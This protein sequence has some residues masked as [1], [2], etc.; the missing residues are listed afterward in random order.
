MNLVSVT[1]RLVFFL[2]W[3]KAALEFDMSNTDE[4]S[5]MSQIDAMQK[6]F[7]S[8]QR[9]ESLLKL[10]TLR[11][12]SSQA[13][14]HQHDTNGWFF[15]LHVAQ[16][17]AS[18]L[19][20]LNTS[21]SSGSE[22]PHT[23]AEALTIVLEN[24]PPLSEIPPHAVRQV[25]KGVMHAMSLLRYAQF[26]QE[27]GRFW[28]VSNGVPDLHNDANVSYWIQKDVAALKSTNFSNGGWSTNA[29]QTSV[30]GAD[31]HVG[32]CHLFRIDAAAIDGPLELNRVLGWFI[33]HSMPVVVS[34]LTDEWRAHSNWAR[35]NLLQAHGEQ[36]LQLG[37]NHQGVATANI[38]VG[39]NNDG[40][41]TTLGD[42]IKQIMPSYEAPMEGRKGKKGKKGKKGRKGKKGKRTW[43]SIP[44]YL[45]NSKISKG[46]ASQWG[47]DFDNPAC[48]KAAGLASGTPFV[49]TPEVITCAC[50]RCYQHS[51]TSTRMIT[52]EHFPLS[53]FLPTRV[54]LDCTD[55]FPIPF[56]PLSRTHLLSAKLWPAPPIFIVGPPLSGAE[57]HMHTAAWN[58]M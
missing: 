23:A 42:Y 54:A 8:E 34:G 30:G 57:L 46:L 45:F 20:E 9:W 19:L 15:A 26:V 56:S 25:Q 51:T 2:S 13:M 37:N 32:R 31:L 39:Q 35:E 14:L 5:V 50:M 29:I 3:S 36:P 1:V 55:C 43:G 4:Q 49:E 28:N 40:G 53:H 33:Q 17:Y 41:S 52:Q 44:P 47:A 48:F 12:K 18:V 6:R 58:G 21:T 22:L 27:R 10:A 24:T 16:E 38:T 7:R 11:W